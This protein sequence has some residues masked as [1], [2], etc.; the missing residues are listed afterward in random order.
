MVLDQGPLLS[1][2]PADFLCVT[3][4]HSDPGSQF[5]SLHFTDEEMQAQEGRESCQ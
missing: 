3:D 1:P 4:P 2:V 5:N